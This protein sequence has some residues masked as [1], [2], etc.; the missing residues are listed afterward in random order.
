MRSYPTIKPLTWHLFSMKKY[1]THN[2][3]KKPNNGH[4]CQEP[5]L[6]KSLLEQKEIEVPLEMPPQPPKKTAPGQWH[7]LMGDMISTAKSSLLLPRL[8]SIPTVQ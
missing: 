3:L 5:W 4:V 7:D 1:R 8:Y 6:H 2:H